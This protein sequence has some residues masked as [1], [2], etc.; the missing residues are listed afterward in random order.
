[1]QKLGYKKMKTMDNKNILDSVK[2]PLAVIVIFAGIVNVAM[3]VTLVKLPLEMQKI[4]IWFVM[5]FP[6]ALVGLFFFIL[7]KKPAVLFSPSDYQND[8]SYLASIDSRQNFE[9]MNLK[10]DQLEQVINTMQ[11]I[12]KKFPDKVSQDGKSLE[13]SEEKR[14]LEELKK[15]KE[16][17]KNNLYSFLFRE[18]KL[19]HAQ[20]KSIITQSADG[21]DLPNSAY[22]LTNNEK[23]KTRV[24]RLIESFPG[25]LNDF[26]QLLTS[27][28]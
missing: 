4:F 12:F 1:M 17:E 9:K 20:I 24:E 19:D 15:I 27:L 23:V 13:I 25:V 3:T 21:K 22:K 7:Y 28:M 16:L 11:D 10:V 14:R 5:F 18:L 2:N 26:A 8:D 6:L